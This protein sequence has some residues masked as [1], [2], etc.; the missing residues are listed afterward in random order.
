[1]RILWL[2]HLVPYPP[3]GGVLQRAH[4]MLR[5]V[6]NYHEV[7]LLAFNQKYLIA[8]FFPSVEAGLEEAKKALD[9][10]C[11]KIIFV[12]IPV[13]KTKY[14]KHLMALKSLVSS[15]PYTINWLKSREYA[16]QLKKLLAENDY[17]LI[18]FDTISLLP[19]FGAIGNIPAV[20]DHHN[21]ESHM[22]LRR[23]ENESSL[24]KKWYYRQE[25]L[26][27]E[28]K[29]KKY[30]PK[31]SLNIT[32]S[33]VD[34]VRLRDISPD[35][36]VVEVPNGVDVDYFKSDKTVQQR[37]SLIFVGTLSWYPNIE[38]VNFIA[39]ELWPAL[40]SEMPEV[41]VDIIGANPPEDLVRLASKD[42]RF[43]VHGFV[44]DVRP[45]L[46]QASV[47]ICPINDGGGTKLK[48]LDALSMKK[49]IV[50]HPVAC[51]GIAV[52]EGKNVLF[53]E[54]VAQYIVA[55]KQ[56]LEKDS[57]RITMGNA[58]REL[59]EEKYSYS[60]IGKSLSELY[61]SHIKK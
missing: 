58:A 26:R 17:D 28:V 9:K 39:Y 44:D 18:H 11:K 31:F 34:A 32:C 25:G 48:I 41:S 60:K 36:N 47:Y 45:H 1:M 15:D 42:S 51:E 12:D 55:I 24:L 4:Y 10:H 50:A 53:A 23:A 5:E 21:I 54:S 57:L 8:P 6:T 22:L 52:T 61:L 37:L 19:Y 49:A 27:L 13:D 29:E 30:C 56:L 38:A 20:L 3:K 2:S 33:E 59:V 43:R 7:D 14:G 35:S 46:D 40:K 16:Q